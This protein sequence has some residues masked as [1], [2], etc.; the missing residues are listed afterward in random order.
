M[1]YSRMAGSWQSTLPENILTVILSV[2]SSV[3]LGAGTSASAR[4]TN[5]RDGA[6]TPQQSTLSIRLKKDNRLKNEKPAINVKKKSW[7]N[8]GSNNN[9]V[10][11]DEILYFRPV[12]S[13]RSNDQYRGFRLGI[14]HHCFREWKIMKFQSFNLPDWNSLAFGSAASSLFLILSNRFL[15]RASKEHERIVVSERRLQ[16]RYGRRIQSIVPYP[17]RVSTLVNS[18][19]AGRC[20]TR[21]VAS[22]SVGS[23]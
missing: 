16:E 3:G 20:L 22:W 14:S 18:G 10:F 7:I 6:A 5:R 12:M 9:N 11:F 2:S 19:P 23:P 17:D 4:R 15:H 1:R 13:T 21:R 8:L